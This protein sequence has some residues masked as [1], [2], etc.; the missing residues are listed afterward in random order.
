MVTDLI[1]TVLATLARKRIKEEG[2]QC[3]NQ[4]TTPSNKL[5][6]SKKNR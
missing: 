3:N 5:D 1:I 6:K 2:H 4:Y